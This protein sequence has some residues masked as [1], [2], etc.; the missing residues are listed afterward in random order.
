MKP[1]LHNIT[2]SVLLL[3]ALFL[4]TG[5]VTAQDAAVQPQ[6]RT[7]LMQY[8]IQERPVLAELL[9]T[10]GMAPTLSGSTGYTLLAPPEEALKNLKGQSAEKIRITLAMH[11]IK[12]KHRESDLKD[13]GKLE[14]YGG[15][16][17]NVCRKK[18]QT[19]INGVKVNAANNEVRNGL[20]HELTGMLIP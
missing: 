4:S 16:Q 10:A 6:Q 18:D 5:A 19:L 20:V 12:G 9:T 1:N 8:L 11:V 13:G 7:T 3:V 14:T 17:V 15:T 2:L